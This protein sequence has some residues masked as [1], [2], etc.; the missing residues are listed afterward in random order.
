MALATCSSSQ[1][2]GRRMLFIYLFILAVLSSLWGLSSLAKGLNLGHNSEST[3]H[4]ALTT[5][6]PGNS[7][8][9][10]QP[11]PPNPGPLPPHAFYMEGSRQAIWNKGSMA[12]F[13]WIFAT[14]EVFLP[15]GLCYPH[16][17]WE[18]P[19]LVFQLYLTVVFVDSFWWRN[20]SYS[21]CCY[22]A[23]T[24]FCFMEPN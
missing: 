7:N 3:V 16:R 4:S 15:L 13:G 1:G 6:P 23:W 12:F 8:L 17:A 11:T 24:V 19:L 10:P 20:L 22:L 5:G 14:K 18:L 9:P 21:S 2:K